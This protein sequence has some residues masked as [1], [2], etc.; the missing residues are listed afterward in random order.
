MI[1]NPAGAGIFNRYP[2]APVIEFLDTA[3]QSP[4]TKSVSHLEL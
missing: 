4:D 3:G 2:H 1:F